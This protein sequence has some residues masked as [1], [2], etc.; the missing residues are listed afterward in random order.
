MAGDDFCRWLLS[1]CDSIFIAIYHFY[2]SPEKATWQCSNI[3]SGCHPYIFCVYCDEFGQ[4]VK[5]KGQRDSSTRCCA[6]S[7]DAQKLMSRYNN[8]YNCIVMD[9]YVGCHSVHLCAYCVA[10][11]WPN[12][13]DI[14][15]FFRKA[16]ISMKASSF[17]AAFSRSYCVAISRLKRK[18]SRAQC[19]LRSVEAKIESIWVCSARFSVDLLLLHP[20]KGRLFGYCFVA[21]RN[22]IEFDFYFQLKRSKLFVQPKKKRTRVILNVPMDVSKLAGN[23]TKHTCSANDIY[24]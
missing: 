5:R 10:P 8:Y 19:S 3:S 11:N 20:V 22:L 21:T 15:Y 4:F 24:M 17:I 18:K 12:G 9:K 13:S 7:P 1:I 16:A 6:L 23:H 14:F 2:C